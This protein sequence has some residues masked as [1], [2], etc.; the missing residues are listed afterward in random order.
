M[1]SVC[2]FVVRLALLGFL[3]PSLSAAAS[4]IDRVFVEQDVVEGKS[5]PV[6]TTRPSQARPQGLPNSGWTARG[7]D[8]STTAPHRSSLQEGRPGDWRQRLRERTER[9]WAIPFPQFDL[10]YRLPEY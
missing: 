9:W 5:L 2:R 10:L 3:M 4:K 8:E 1:R 6:E 7:Q